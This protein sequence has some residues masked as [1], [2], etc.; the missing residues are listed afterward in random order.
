MDRD[1]LESWLDSPHRTW[2]WR[3]DDDHDRYEAVRTTD[4]GL[5]WYG[6]SHIPEERGQRREQRQS[7]AAFRD[8]GPPRKV[9][10]T[11][12]AELTRWVAEHGR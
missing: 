11:V 10:D 8:D 4:Q 3:F 6:W 12:L 7:F 2:R 1:A 9:P 5:L